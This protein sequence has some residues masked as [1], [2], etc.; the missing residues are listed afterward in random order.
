ML[1]SRFITATVL[2]LMAAVVAGGGEYPQHCFHCVSVLNCGAVLHWWA[3]QWVG[4]VV[5]DAV[6][7]LVG[8]AQSDTLGVAEGE[9]AHR[10]FVQLSSRQQGCGQHEPGR[11]DASSGLIGYQHSMHAEHA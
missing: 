6:G 5:G 7:A 3:T 8:V 4:K 2:L 10:E 11:R 1:L 9:V